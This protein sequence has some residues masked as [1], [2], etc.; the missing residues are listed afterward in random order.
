MTTKVL[1][2]G[3]NKYPNAPLRGCYADAEDTANRLYKYGVG[4]RDQDGV[5]NERA[6]CFGIGYR[7]MRLVR[8]LNPGDRGALFFSGHGFQLPMRNSDEVD[9]MVEGLCPVDFDPDKP[10]TWILDREFI[11][12]LD[13]IKDGVD[14]TVVLDSCFSGGMT[15]YR[16]HTESDQDEIRTV[17]TGIS[18]RAYPI[19][20]RIDF[21][22]RTEA[23]KERKI[24]PL[25]FIKSVS[26]SCPNVCFMVGCGEGQTCADAYFPDVRYRGAFTKMLWDTLAASPQLSRRE[27]IEITREELKSAG[28]SQTPEIYGPDE[29]ILKPFLLGGVR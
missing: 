14:F 24:R 7:L 11:S 26:S 23:A 25:P 19:E 18:S 29:L 1:I 4:F 15:D 12:M 5:T 13:D 28:F 17:K 3:I 16:Y 2:V 10:I 22:I 8:S 27:V 21:K 20:K 6:T 9:G